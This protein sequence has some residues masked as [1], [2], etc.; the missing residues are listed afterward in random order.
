MKKTILTTLAVSLIS[1]I[2]ISA[3]TVG[4]QADELPYTENR[5]DASLH[6]GDVFALTSTNYNQRGKDEIGGFPGGALSASV[7]A[8][9][10]LTAELGLGVD[11]Q[12]VTRSIRSEQ[13]VNGKKMYEIEVRHPAGDLGTDLEAK[14]LLPSF[15]T[16]EEVIE[17]GVQLTYSVGQTMK[18]IKGKHYKAINNSTGSTYDLPLKVVAIS[19]H[20]VIWTEYTD[21]SYTSTNG[22]SIATAQEAAEQFEIAYPIVHNYVGSHYDANKDGK[23][24]LAYYDIR[25]GYES[26]GS[27]GYIAGYFAPSDLEGGMNN[28]DVINIDTNPGSAPNIST[29]VHE[30]THLIN[31]SIS[32]RRGISGWDGWMD[33]GLAETTAQIFAHFRPLNDDPTFPTS[34]SNHA[35]GYYLDRF[36]HWNN[37]NAAKN[38]EVSLT[39]WG[40][41]GNTLENYDY[42]TMWFQYLRL[43]T[44][45][46]TLTEGQ[47]TSFGV[48]DLEWGGYNLTRTMESS[49]YRSK[50]VYTNLIIKLL[51]ATTTGYEGYTYEDLLIDFNL[52]ITL[53]ETSGKFSFQGDLHY[54]FKPYFTT[55][56]SSLTIGGI[57]YVRKYSNIQSYTLAQADRS[58]VH[59]VS[60]NHQ[61]GPFIYLTAPSIAA[62][63]GMTEEYKIQVH[64]E[65]QGQPFNEATPITWTVNDPSRASVVDGK[66]SFYKSGDIIVTATQGSLVNSIGVSIQDTTYAIAWAQQIPEG[67]TAYEIE[68]DQSIV[69]T[70]NVT[71]DL[72]GH[73]SDEVN[74]A[75]IGPVYISGSYEKDAE[76][77]T[78]GFR[79][80]GKKVSEN[81]T[82]QISAT[83]NTT[84][85]KLNLKVVPST[86]VPPDP[87][88]VTEEEETTGG[89]K[90]GSTNGALGIVIA[91]T[92]FGF[93]FLLKK[94][95]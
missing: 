46:L 2:A 37:S 43:L 83:I 65:K 51:Q 19:E 29:I 93:V 54:S 20:A 78:I 74:F 55:G 89:C 14:K 79:V 22:I 49:T 50:N 77:H 85:V 69:F 44:T 21:G 56:P 60:I 31:H 45:G 30:Y 12:G 13:V 91:S 23:L 16:P 36:D 94:K 53:N 32:L 62:K 34:P 11:S 28:M 68:V 86:Y 10:P 92:L 58:K 35:N 4:A 47:R 71:P 27:G 61:T 3:K 48:P 40:Y 70:V 5:N 57:V 88:S 9:N 24:S 90:K 26:N 18:E 1:I 75:V 67:S 73:K 41:N 15:P 66:L 59:L 25:D 64:L 17:D 33:E 52:A 7:S 39:I 95:H 63:V 72:N 6:L 38:H 84:N 81:A 8:E 82:V 76:N 80:T 42:A 87:G